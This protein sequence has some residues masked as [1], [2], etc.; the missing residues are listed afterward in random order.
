[1]SSPRRLELL[2]LLGQA[3]RTV[4]AIASEAGMSIANTSQHLQA[5]RAARLVEASKDGLFVTYRQASEEV[6]QFYRSLR[7]LAAARLRASSGRRPSSR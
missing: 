7:S 2:D 3:P 4:E 1:M 5:L 6:A